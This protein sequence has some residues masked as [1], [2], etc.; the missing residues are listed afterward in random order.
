MSKGKTEKPLQREETRWSSSLF[1]LFL[2]C[3]S[4]ATTL[5]AFSV[6]SMFFNRALEG[7]FFSDTQKNWEEIHALHA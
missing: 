6:S 5:L 4:S 3:R 2:S 1:V 7:S